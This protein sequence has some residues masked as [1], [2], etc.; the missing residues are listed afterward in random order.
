MIEW[1]IIYNW[2]WNWVSIFQIN[3]IIWAAT[4]NY[5]FLPTITSWM[6]C[7]VPL[8]MEETNSKLKNHL[9]YL[10]LLPQ[11]K[12]WIRRNLDF[13][14]FLASTWFSFSLPLQLFILLF[15]ASPFSS[16]WQKYTNIKFVLATL[17][18]FTWGLV[19]EMVLLYVRKKN[20]NCFCSVYELLRSEFIPCFDY[21]NLLFLH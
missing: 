15:L 20:V 3:V 4:T 8:K 7:L 9:P 2:D 13:A 17:A 18:V 11:I 16:S 5:R 19:F 12:H 6:L 1:N 21:V 10:L 14:R